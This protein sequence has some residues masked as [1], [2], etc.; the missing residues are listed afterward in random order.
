M[1]LLTYL[2]LT[3]NFNIILNQ[4]HS[5]YLHDFTSIPA[6]LLAIFLK[7]IHFPFGIQVYHKLYLN[8]YC[9]ICYVYFVG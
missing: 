5:I 2:E 4:F 6:V 7:K 1:Y 8:L 3:P 9:F